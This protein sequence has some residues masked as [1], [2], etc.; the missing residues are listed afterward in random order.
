MIAS[1][2]IMFRETLEAAL[3]VGIV[4]GYLKKIKKTEYNKTVYLGVI[5]GAISSMIGAILFNIIAGG[6]SGVAEEVFEGITMLVGAFM[7]TT[8]ILWMMKQRNIAAELESKVSLEIDE[9]HTAGLFFLVFISILREGIET[10]IFLSAASFISQE[11]NITGALIGIAIAIILGYFIFLGSVNINLKKFFSVTSVLLILFAAGL[12]AH[13][14]H[15]LQ[16]AGVVPI[17]LE[18][19][20]NINPPQNL[21]G[22][23]PLLHDKGAIGEILKGLFGYNGNPSLIEVLSY[24]AF[25]SLIGLTWYKIAQSKAVNV[26]GVT[27]K[28]K[29][30]ETTH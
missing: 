1:L 6:F 21:D 17:I 24:I 11:N 25:I 13:G 2:L 5:I 22:S 29:V 19:V 14:I 4:L 7:L 10:V 15:E 9:K 18:E 30:L 16:E 20:W 26:K 12:I 28:E 27:G 3:I 23:Y 8:M